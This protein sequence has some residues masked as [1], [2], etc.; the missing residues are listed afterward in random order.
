MNELV[1]TYIYDPS[2]DYGSYSVYACYNNMQDYDNRVVEFYDLYDKSGI[3]VNEGEPF[4]DMPSW[5]EIFEYYWLPTIREAKK[6]HKRDL[7]EATK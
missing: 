5:K 4:Y 1:A 2:V 3:C 7:K 6:T